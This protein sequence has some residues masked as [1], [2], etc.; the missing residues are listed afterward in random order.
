LRNPGLSVRRAARKD[1]TQAAIVE[2]LRKSYCKVKVLND[3]P[4][5]LVKAPWG[6]YFAIEVDGVTKNRKR[7]P[8]QLEFLETWKIPRVSTLQQAIAAIFG[9]RE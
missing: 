9:G 4:D 3:T 1:E 7:N 6:A 5:L 2:G 8:A